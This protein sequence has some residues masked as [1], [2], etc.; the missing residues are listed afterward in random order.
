MKKQQKLAKQD[1]GSGPTTV[2][3][4][5]KMNFCTSYFKTPGQKSQNMTVVQNKSAGSS[6][7]DR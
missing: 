5:K 2:G 3:G 4:G 7:F 6:S 1:K